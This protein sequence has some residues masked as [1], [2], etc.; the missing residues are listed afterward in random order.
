MLTPIEVYARLLALAN[1]RE[2]PRRFK[3]DLTT[4]DRKWLFAN[5]GRP[6]V[7]ILYPEGTHLVHFLRA[8]PTRQDLA[9]ARD[10]LDTCA[11]IFGLAA[12]Y[13][14]DGVSVRAFP[15]HRE[16]LEALSPARETV[17]ATS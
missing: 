4:H 15:S 13:A 3:S 9:Q 5:P 12:Y 1:E 17:E 8:A 2:M 14:F 16:A 11:D 10:V 6:F 7:W